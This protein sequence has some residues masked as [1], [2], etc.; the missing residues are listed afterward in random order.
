MRLMPGSTG[1]TAPRSGSG[2]V[3]K[4]M[5]SSEWGPRVSGDA[6]GGA[7]RLRVPAPPPHPAP[8]RPE[9][10]EGVEA[11]SSVQKPGR[12]GGLGDLADLGQEAGADRDA[13]LHPLGGDLSLRVAR[14]HHRLGG[15]DRRGGAE[16]AE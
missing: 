1:S 8:L 5:R 3:R 13:V 9:G 12:G 7:N 11:R 14:N 10:G 15:I 16:V 4:A 2:S 6:I